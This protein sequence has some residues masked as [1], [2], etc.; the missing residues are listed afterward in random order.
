MSG[1]AT[2]GLRYLDEHEVTVASLLLRNSDDEISI[3]DFHNENRQLSSGLGFR[4]YRFEFEE[5]EML[6]NQVKVN[7]F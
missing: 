7:I 3:S 5:R 6:V 4:G 1:T 2:F